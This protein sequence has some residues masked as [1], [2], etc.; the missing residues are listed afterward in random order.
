MAVALR[1]DPEYLA[2]VSA[3]PQQERPDTFEDVFELRNFT[4]AA[5]YSSIRVLPTPA[6]I[7]ETKI[8][9]KSLDNAT[10]NIHRFASKGMT[11]ASEPGPAVVFAH[12]GGAISCSVD[13]YAPQIVRYVADTGITFFAV[14]YGLA[15]EH[16]APTP[17]GDV[18]AG[19]KYILSHAAE[20]NIDPKRVAI[21]GDEAGKEDA[22]VS[23]YSAPARAKD[24][25][26][27]PTTY[28][29]V[30]G[31]DLF[32]AEDISYA[33]RIAAEDIEVEV[34][35]WPGLPHVYEVASQATVVKMALDA[36]LRALK[37]F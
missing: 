31:L 21:M 7:T 13:V 17:T 28:I 6:N 29:E 37:A 34:H 25:R 22:D 32:R 8:K 27:L 11:E 30:G 9:Y 26:D 10:V 18:F 16:P 35:L 12:G 3:F 23:I 15:P 4:E 36:R 19:L 20:L 14:D 33:N 1:Y 24:V 5:L 2:A